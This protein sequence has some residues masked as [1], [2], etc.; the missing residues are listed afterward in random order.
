MYLTS[1]KTLYLF[2]QTNNDYNIIIASE[3]DKKAVY[4]QKANI[5]PTKK[6]ALSNNSPKSFRLKGSLFTLTVMHLIS[7]DLNQFSRELEQTIAK[8]PKFFKHAP[9]VIDLNELNNSEQEIDLNAISRECRKQGLIPVGIRGGNA[10]L[11]EIAIQAGLAILAN[12]QSEQTV[13]KKIQK[14][15][16][17]SLKQEQP[18]HQGTKVITQPV[19]SGQQIYAKGGDLIVLSPVSVG[20]EILADGHLHIYAPLRGR[21]LAGV[22]GDTTARIFC[23]SIEAELISIAGRYLVSEQ[24]SDYFEAQN[25]QIHLENDQLRF[26]TLT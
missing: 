25:M 19:R 2:L 8:S 7:N 18:Q 26:T 23:K 1:I 5:M 11:K 16:E 6:T 3:M 14:K 24:L 20:A 9:I 4:Y 17:K 21:A 13:Q 22:L 10:K 12:T 15:E